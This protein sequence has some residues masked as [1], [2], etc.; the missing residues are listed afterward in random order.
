[1][2]ASRRILAGSALA[3]TFLALGLL[4]V[5]DILEPR[6]EVAAE[7]AR[8]AQL[9]Q[10]LEDLFSRVA[11]NVK[12]AVVAI[13]AES[14]RLAAPGTEDEDQ[15]GDRPHESIGSGFVIDP[16]GYVL[17][18][19]HLI[20]GARRIR[21]RFWDSRECWGRLVQSDPSCDLA[22]LRVPEVPAGGLRHLTLGDSEALRVGQWVLAIGNPFGLTQ[23][24]SAGIIS[25]LK[26]TDLRIL[27]NESFIQT[28][29]SI[30]PGNSGG[31]LVSLRGEAI[32]INTAIYAQPGGGNQGISFAVPSNLA[33]ALVTRWMEGKSISFLGIVPGRV[34]TDM[35]RY[36]KLPS[37]RGAFVRSVEADGP[38]A[39][40]GLRPK[41]IILRFGAAEVH[42]E[43]HLRVL[44]AAAPANEPT[45][46]EVLR[47]ERRELLAVTPVENEA[48]RPSAA[49]DA[50]A[51]AAEPARTRLLGITLA[52]LAPRLAEQ[53][54]L[55]PGTR[56]VAVVEV[57]P[58]SAAFRK[59]LRPGDLIVEINERPVARTDEIR[60]ILAAADAVIMVRLERRGE[61]SELVFLP[62]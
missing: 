48:G 8:E 36:F 54:G 25:A 30:N 38:G 33:R 60:E 52:T 15:G 22:L 11:E 5:R 20:D 47:D 56:G 18:N 41:D 61:G 1:V 49:G 21:I 43:N 6:F 19:H 17:T 59:G 40:A 44:I 58:D 46:V 35:A 2:S 7:P 51:D 24:V 14:R 57:Q 3:G 12:L 45:Q 32:G 39:Q 23:T 62:R 16:R 42:D 26:R 31:P 50:D 55:A 28:D 34:D 27:P 29:A 10:E 9:A 13:E 53:L 4:W 37:P